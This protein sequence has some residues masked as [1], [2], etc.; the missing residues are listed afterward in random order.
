MDK[1]MKTRHRIKYLRRKLRQCR[2]SYANLIELWELAEAGMLDGE[3]ELLEA[4]GV[5]E[6]PEE[7]CNA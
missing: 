1:I 4:A 5:P 7:L 2:I 3:T 6:F